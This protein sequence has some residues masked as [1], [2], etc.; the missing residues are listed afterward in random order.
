MSAINIEFEGLYLY[1]IPLELHYIEDS[2]ASFYI[3]LLLWSF[4]AIFYFL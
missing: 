1:Q 4:K 3:C 2:Y